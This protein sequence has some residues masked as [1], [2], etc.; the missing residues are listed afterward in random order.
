MRSIVSASA[1]RCRND[2]AAL[3]KPMLASATPPD[4]IKNLR[5]IVAPKLWV[6]GFGCWQ[7]PFLTPHT[8]PP[9]PCL[10]SLKL[11]RAQNQA[12]NLNYRVVDFRRI[13]SRQLLL[14][15]G[16]LRGIGCLHECV[17]WVNAVRLSRHGSSHCRRTRGWWQSDL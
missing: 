14:T 15:S 1:V 3:V 7:E 6:L 12:N 8:L 2:G 13:S 11:R 5:F 9:T 4:V 17:N 10:L 16:L